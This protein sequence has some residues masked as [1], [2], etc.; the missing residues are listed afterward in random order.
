[1]VSIR[2]SRPTRG[3]TCLVLWCITSI[4]IILIS[5]FLKD[6]YLSVIIETPE[7]WWNLTC[8]KYIMKIVLI[9]IVI[10][11]RHVSSLMTLL[12]SLSNIWTDLIGIP[13]MDI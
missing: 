5:G 4:N 9:L 13:V 6:N 1:M 10:I 3:T 7:I 2:A 11:E 12:L 8:H